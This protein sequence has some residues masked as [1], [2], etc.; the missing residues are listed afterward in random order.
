MERFIFLLLLLA[1]CFLPGCHSMAIRGCKVCISSSCTPNGSK[2]LL[3]AMQTLVSTEAELDIK[4]DSCLGGC[5][6]GVIVKTVHPG[7]PFSK[8]RSRALDPLI[9]EAMAIRAAADL[10]RELDGLDETIL[11]SLEAKL[12]SSDRALSH[13]EP[14][15]MC[16]QC[17]VAMQLYRGNCA[18]CGKYPY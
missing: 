18:K 4:G 2:M 9:D 12:A 5:G 1:A 17:G 14:P 8:N 15:E 3:D 7:A 16:A 11:A 10:L 13:S 6:G